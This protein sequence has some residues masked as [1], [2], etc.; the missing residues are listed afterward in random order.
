MVITIDPA[1]RLVDAL[2][3]DEGLSNSPALLPTPTDGG[4]ELWAC[5][6]DTAATFDDL[7]RAE[8]GSPEQAETYLANRFYRNIASGLS[9]TEEYMA[10]EKLHQLHADP[11]FDASSWTLRPAATPWTSSRPPAP[12]PGSSTTGCSSC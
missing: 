8:A 6:L 12:S 9:G 5:M 11:R 1:K 10:A 3:L 7:V 4:G 2:G